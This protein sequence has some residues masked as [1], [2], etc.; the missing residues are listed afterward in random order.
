MADISGQRAGTRVARGQTVGLQR[1]SNGRRKGTFVA[2]LVWVIVWIAI[3]LPLFFWGIAYYRLPLSERPFSPLHDLF[4]PAGIVGH[5]LGVAGTTMM[6][7]GVTLYSVRKRIRAL[8][9]IGTL[10]SWLRFHIFLCTLGPFLVLLHT[11]FR[12]GGLVAI[13]FWSM[14][15]VVASGIF[16]RYVYAHI[17]KGLNGRFRTL[18]ALRLEQETLIGEIA[19][20]SA[21][22]P[23]AVRS[24]VE[25]T[26]GQASGFAGAVFSMLRFDLSTRTRPI[27]H[28]LFRQ[29][30]APSA[31]RDLALLVRTHRRLDL[32]RTFL[33]PFQR[34]FKYW[35][36]FHMPLAFLM[37]VIV[38]VHVGVAVAF[39]YGWIFQ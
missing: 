2:P 10:R 5:G 30:V 8:A 18:Q 4:K 7:V 6:V 12:F 16:G 39:G 35:H 17:P 1:P 21:L 34:M 38:V 9:R 28:Q 15:T 37:L 3:A 11:S 29:G 23:E 13:A 27:E 26:R 32:E 33:E 24:I 20:G 22:P 19:E 25:G 31:A 14:A 36:A